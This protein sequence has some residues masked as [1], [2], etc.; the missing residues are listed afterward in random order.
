MNLQRLDRLIREL[1]ITDEPLANFYKNKRKILIKKINKNVAR[2]LKEQYLYRI[3]QT[4]KLKIKIMGTI[5]R[6]IKESRI[7]NNQT[8]I[9]VVKLSTGL[10]CYHYASGRIDVR[11]EQI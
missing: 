5:I 11:Y 9:K 2:K 3:K 7:K 6:M 1:E 8:P 4:N 10:T